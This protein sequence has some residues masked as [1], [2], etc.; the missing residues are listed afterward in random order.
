MALNLAQRAARHARL[1]ARAAG[2]TDVG[3]PPF[4]IFFIN[5]I[6]NLKCEH[7]FVWDRLNQ[8]DDLSF[9]EIVALSEDLGPVENLNLSGGEPFMREDFAQVCEQFITCNGVKQ[10]YVPT[11]GYYTE[12]TVAAVEAVLANPTL[13]LLVLEFSLDGMPEFHDRFR[14]N[15]RSFAKAM[16]TIDAVSTLQRR[17]PRLRIHSI[18]TATADNLEEIRQLTTYLF[19]RHPAMDHQNIAIIRGDR[20][21]PSLQG[22]ALDAYLDLDRY[23]KRLWAGREQARFG[24]V[25]DP[26][27]T[28]AKVRT[29][30]ERR[31][32]IPCK[33]GI[34]SAVVYANGDV[35][36]CET[37]ASHPVLGNLRERSFREIW[38]SPE[39]VEA[40]RKIACKECHCTNEVFLWPSV[41]FQPFQLARALAGARTWQTLE[42][43]RED[44]RAAVAIGEDGLPEPPT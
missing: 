31:Q 18:A 14:G 19:E 33:A 3:T 22:P 42:P 5:S 4:L 9:D 23:A 15:P 27:L 24:A 6:C 43:L 10:I 1:S 16:E 37:L 44:E 7:C 38:Y 40:R 13:D 25:V 20:K 17:D 28:W 26:M 11:N 41:V 39:A 8:R 2:L 29:A 34:L 35:G 32:V 12:S 30:R 21:N 36:V